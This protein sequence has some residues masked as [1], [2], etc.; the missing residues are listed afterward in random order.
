MSNNQPPKFIDGMRVF[1]PHE[2]APKWV[3]GELVV[4]CQEFE[5][6]MRANCDAQGE[7]R[8]SIKESKSDKLYL[9]RNDWRPQR[10]NGYQQNNSQPEQQQNHNQG[11]GY[12]P[13][14]PPPELPEDDEDSDI[15][16]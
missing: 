2:R 4:N 12:Q 8:I 13:A 6:Y 7:L 10:Q 5:N 9:E 11:Q 1:D 14:T 16:F 3:K 15:P